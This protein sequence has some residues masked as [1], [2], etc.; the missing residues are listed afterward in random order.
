MGKVL[1]CDCDADEFC[2]ADVL[3]GM[4]FELTLSLRI[5]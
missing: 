2:E 5:H 1:V 3:A 4:V